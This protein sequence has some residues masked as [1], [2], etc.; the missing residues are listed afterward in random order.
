MTGNDI[1]VLTEAYESMFAHNCLAVTSGDPEEGEP[2]IIFTG[3]RQECEQ[4]MRTHSD[5]NDL[6]Y[7]MRTENGL[8]ELKKYASYAL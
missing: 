6:Y 8:I 7:A 3:N 5:W 2:T 1:R 4:Y